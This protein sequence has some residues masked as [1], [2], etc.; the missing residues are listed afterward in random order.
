MKKVL[1]G[2]TNTIRGSNV[3]FYGCQLVETHMVFT[4]LHPLQ[5]LNKKSAQRDANTG[6]W[7]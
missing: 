1:R 5:L 3:K 4:F 2:D 6:H 7:L